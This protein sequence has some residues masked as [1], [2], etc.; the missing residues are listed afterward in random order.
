[1]KSS[2]ILTVAALVAVSAAQVRASYI[3]LSTPDN[4]APSAAV[5]VSGANGGYSGAELNNLLVSDGVPGAASFEDMGVHF[6][7]PEDSAPYQVSLTWTTPQSLKSLQAYVGHGDDVGGSFPDAD[8][9]VSAISFA[10]DY[11]LGAG[12][13]PV[14]AVDTVDTDDVGSFDLTKLD[15]NWSNVIAVGYQFTGSS[16]TQGPRV[17]EVLAIASVPEPSTFVLLVAGLIGLLAYAWRKRR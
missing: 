17:A 7:F 15:G 13:E 16:G 4:V 11:G 5:A 14:G 8:R 10:V 9:T 1:M 2:L 6:I 12:W 3:T